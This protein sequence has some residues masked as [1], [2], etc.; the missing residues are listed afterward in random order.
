MAKR[1]SKQTCQQQDAQS[2]PKQDAQSSPKPANVI[3]LATL[4]VVGGS[5]PLVWV[6]Q[7]SINVRGDIPIATLRFFSAIHDHRSEACCLQTSIALLHQMADVICRLTNHY[8]QKP[9]P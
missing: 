3:E 9:E 6:D 1:P 4:P 7:M 5:P 2:S 8:P